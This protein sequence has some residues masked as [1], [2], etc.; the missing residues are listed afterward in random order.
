MQ[1]DGRKLFIGG[2]SRD[3]T[4]QSLASFYQQWGDTQDVVVMKDPMTGRSRGFGFVTFITQQGVS[5]AKGWY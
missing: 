3:T 2:L 4:D 1:A 5:P